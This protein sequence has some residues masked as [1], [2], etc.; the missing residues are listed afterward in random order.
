MSKIVHVISPIDGKPVTVRPASGTTQH[1]K[2]GKCWSVFCN[3]PI[4]FVRISKSGIA[5]TGYCNG[6]TRAHI[7]ENVVKDFP[8]R[9]V[10]HLVWRRK[11]EPWGLNQKTKTFEPLKKSRRK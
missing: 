8:T 10:W 7:Y 1:F 5:H 6:C 2:K 4:W 9:G 11:L 3:N